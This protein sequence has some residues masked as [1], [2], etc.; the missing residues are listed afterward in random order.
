ML[1]H[2]GFAAFF[3]SASISNAALWMQLV[4]VPALLY[5][6]TGKATWLGISSVA[7]LV[8]SVVLTPYAGVL[9]DR[10]DRR[11]ILLLTQSSTMLL[12]FALWGLYATG[13]ITP[14]W[15]VG[16][17]AAT[18]VSGGFQSAAW[19]AFIPSLVPREEM[20]DA[21]K[22]NSVQFTLARALGPAFAGIVVRA[23]GTGAA[24]FV[25][26]ATYALVIA[27]LVVVRPRETATASRESPSLHALKEGALYV[28]EQEPLRIAV[29]IAFWA[30]TCGQP[31]Q[32][33]SAAI[34]RRL[35]HH[36]STDSS[37]LLAALGLGAVVAS[38]VWTLRGDRLRR[39]THTLLGMAAW[40]LGLLV[41]IATDHFPV[42][43]VGFALGGFAHLTT[44]VGLNTL[45][46]G[47]VPDELR[48]RVV[49]YYLLAILAGIPLGSFAIG[50]LG[51]TFGLRTA[52]VVDLAVYLLATASLVVRGRLAQLDV[53]T[54]TGAAT[55]PR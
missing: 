20:L 38:I 31:L 24:I 42:I 36:P 43:V 54:M 3:T 47:Y 52:M 13:H 17:G 26:A 28:W 35:G 49:S 45:V 50:R 33:V 8:P 32:Y 16:L 4:A 7:S 2:R 23:W 9:S 11:K 40:A 21:V 14:L 41:I 48:G 44:S 34:A 39:S 29:L 51:D 12:T 27:V 30:G 37:I 19:Q 53:T 1:R 55:T 18:G 22:L 5:D 10:M 6:L 25:N 46:Q 15:I